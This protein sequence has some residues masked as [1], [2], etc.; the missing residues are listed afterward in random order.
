MFPSPAPHIGYPIRHLRKA[1]RF[2]R[3]SGMR[4]GVGAGDAFR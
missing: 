2:R 1:P 4:G 3:V